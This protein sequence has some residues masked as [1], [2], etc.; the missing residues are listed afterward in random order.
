[1][2]SRRQIASKQFVY[3]QLALLYPLVEV[4]VIDGQ[5]GVRDMLLVFIK[6]N[7]KR[8]LIIFD[9]FQFDSFFFWLIFVDQIFFQY[10][11]G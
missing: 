4:L 3:G 2:I 5:V 1:M 10:F 8:L 7:V 11:L 6:Q 9:G